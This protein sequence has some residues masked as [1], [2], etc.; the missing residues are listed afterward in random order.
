VVAAAVIFVVI[1]AVELP[2]T[3]R[4]FRVVFAYIGRRRRRAKLTRLLRAV[5]ET[6]PY[7]QHDHEVTTLQARVSALRAAIEDASFD[8]V[9]SAAAIVTGRAHP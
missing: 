8:D 4:K 5:E 3:L 2:D 7:T 9:T 1:E 6:L